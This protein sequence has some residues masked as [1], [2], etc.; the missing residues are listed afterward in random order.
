MAFSP[1]QI[2]TLLSAVI[3]EL[4][5]TSLFDI[6]ATCAQ[7]PQVHVLSLSAQM[8][9]VMTIIRSKGCEREDFVF[10]ADRIVRYVVEEGLNYVACLYSSTELINLGINDYNNDISRI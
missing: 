7:N 4:I 3:K 8:K 9:A 1:D 10:Y 5:N 6:D 2:K